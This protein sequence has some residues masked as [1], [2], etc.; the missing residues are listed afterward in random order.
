LWLTDAP[1]S[2]VREAL[3]KFWFDVTKADWRQTLVMNVSETGLQNR[4]LCWFDL[5]QRFGTP[6]VLLTIGGLV[7]V[8]VRAGESAC[9]CCCCISSIWSSRGRTTSGTCMC[10]LPSHYIV[11]LCAGA[12]VAAVNKGRDRVRS[13]APRVAIASCLAYAAWRGYDT[14]PAV[15]R[16]WDHRPE[17]VVDRLTTA[18]QAELTKGAI[19]GVDAN[20]QVQN[21][22]EYF[23][24]MHK[25]GTPW[26]VFDDLAWLQEG[27][28]TERFQHFSE[29]R[30]HH[31]RIVVT[32]TSHKNFAP[33]GISAPS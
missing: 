9:C 28:A 31:R 2:S 16:S 26:F 20:W 11:A 12:G 14:F 21:A 24:R 7:F 18:S 30:H 15:D 8:M 19:F 4:A 33:P 6:G 10:F 29:E 23:M 32:P 27:D 13:L 3:A 17:Q 5:H 1:P 22:V 25:P